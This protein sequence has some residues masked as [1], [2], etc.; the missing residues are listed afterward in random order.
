MVI[1]L[2]HPFDQNMTLYP[3]TPAP[4]F[5]QLNSLENDGFRQKLITL[6][7]HMGTHVDAPGH[8]LPGG[9]FLDQ[10]T[11]ENFIGAG[12]VIDVRP[13]GKY[14]TPGLV[15]GKI[16]ADTRF[17]LFLTG[18]G[19]YWGQSRYLEDQPALAEETAAYLAGFSL[20]GIGIDTISIDP[21]DS[22][23]LPAHRWILGAGFL[24]LENLNNLHLLLDKTFRIIFLPLLIPQ[25]DGWPVRV[26]AIVEEK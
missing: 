17:V 11:V 25:S 14:I 6:A 16:K 8:I 21:P 10:F 18:F 22:I 20:N 2:S 1:D 13:A 3:G 5:T 26:I 7:S 9:R 23:T 19:S 24:I 15:E 4:V 12:Q